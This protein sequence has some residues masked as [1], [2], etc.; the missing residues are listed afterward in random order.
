MSINIVDGIPAGSLSLVGVLSATEIAGTYIAFLDLPTISRSDPEVSTSQVLTNLLV[1]PGAVVTRA[2]VQVSAA[3]P[4]TTTIGGIAT[5]RAAS[6]EPDSVSDELV[7]DF[8]TLRTVSALAAPS[9]IETV[10]PWAGTKFSGPVNLVKSLSGREVS[11]TELQTE[12]LLVDLAGNVR[13][14]DFASTGLL[15]TTTPPADL[16][17]VVG[18]TRVWF[19]QG[20]VPPGFVETVDVT[21]PVQAVLDSGGPLGEDGNVAVRVAL[22]ARVP[23]ELGLELPSPPRFLRTATIDFPGPTTMAGF[24]EEGLT[25]LVVPFSPV[26]ALPGPTSL[27]SALPEVPGPGLSPGPVLPTRTIHRVV[28]TVAAEDPGPL[29]VLPNVGPAVSTEADMVLNPDRRLVARLPRGPLTRFDHIAGVRLLIGPG[30]GGIEVGGALLGGT[31]LEPGEPLPDGGLVPVSLDAAPTGWVTLALPRPVRLSA[32]LADRGAVWLSVAVT[33]GT[34]QL[35]LADPDATPASELSVLRRVAPNGLTRTPSSVLRERT[36][37]GEPPLAIR[38][39]ALALRV[40]GAAPVE[41]PVPL[42]ELDV[43]GGPTIREA[44]L[45]GSLVISLDPVGPRVPLRLALSTTAATTVRVGPVVVAYTDAA[46][47][48]HA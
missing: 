38:T 14:A 45:D 13:P 34:A 8:G 42:V 7:I 48:D 22:S 46:E 44:G 19:R 9:G 16:E 20:A 33:R 40:V 37:P 47:V 21:A 43:P 41:A 32:L 39:D 6:G 11:F 29:R 30:A 3:A 1:P 15:T 10:T 28:A 24:A 12:R 17:L 35:A 36:A 31:E 23:G 18:A 2:E 27:D 5:V 4:G 26:G 25:E